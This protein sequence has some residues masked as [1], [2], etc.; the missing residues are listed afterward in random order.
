MFELQP[1]QSVVE[2][3]FEEAGPIGKH[4]HFVVK[5]KSGTYWWEMSTFVNGLGFPRFGSQFA[6]ITVEWSAFQ[7]R[8]GFHISLWQ[9][10][11]D[12]G[13]LLYKQR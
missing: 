9:L 1:L 3:L 10:Q 11:V 5:D 13:T 2:V 4:T 7:I 8:Y 6:P 12:K